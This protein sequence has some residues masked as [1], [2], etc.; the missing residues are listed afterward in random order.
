MSARA[1]I[2]EGLIPL[3]VVIVMVVTM[4]SWTLADRSTA[5]PQIT[6]YTILERVEKL[7]RENQQDYK[8]IHDLYERIQMLDRKSNQI[9]TDLNRRID[10]LNQEV[11]ALR[12]RISQLESISD[13]DRKRRAGYPPLRGIQRDQHGNVILDFAQ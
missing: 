1:Y 3:S 9:Q 10:S 4:L 8:S 6:V 12:S 13:A 11:M 7:E 5:Q 2:S